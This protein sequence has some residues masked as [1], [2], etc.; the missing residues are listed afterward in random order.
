[1]RKFLMALAFILVSVCHMAPALAQEAACQFGTVPLAGLENKVVEQGGEVVKVTALN[2]LVFMDALSHV[3]FEV[4][5]RLYDSVALAIWPDQHVNVG[6]VKGECLVHVIFLSAQ[7][8]QEVIQ[9]I[10]GKESK[11]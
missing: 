5:E 6:F 3:G 2:Y 10:Q 4:D 7:Q 11:S 8:A 1:M 9:Y